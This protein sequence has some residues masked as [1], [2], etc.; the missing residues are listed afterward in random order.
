MFACK[1]FHCYTNYP[2]FFRYED[3]LR[4]PL[5]AACGPDA[6]VAVGGNVIAEFH[7]R[8]AVSARTVRST[9]SP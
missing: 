7:R 9:H 4:L 5:T 2:G 6:A 8:G 3:L 1:H